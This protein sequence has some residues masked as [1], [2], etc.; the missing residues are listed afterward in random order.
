MPVTLSIYLKCTTD[1]MPSAEENLKY[2]ED[3]GLWLGKNAWT[4]QMF[5]SHARNWMSKRHFSPCMIK[6]IR[7][8]EIKGHYYVRKT[9]LPVFPAGD[10]LLPECGIHLQA[11][12]IQNFSLHIV[13][14]FI[15]IDFQFFDPLSYFNSEYQAQI[16]VFAHIMLCYILLCYSVLILFKLRVNSITYWRVFIGSTTFN[17]E[18]PIIR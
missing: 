13:S 8:W 3:V 10:E 6:P 9:W 16:S 5:G 17:S 7:N 18:V 14:N 11:L 15:F 4:L 2:A 1:K 12:F